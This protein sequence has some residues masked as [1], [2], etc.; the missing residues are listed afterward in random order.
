MRLA[1][2][3][4]NFGVGFNFGCKSRMDFL[5]QYDTTTLLGHV[6]SV[7]SQLFFRGTLSDLLELNW[8]QTV[9]RFSHSHSNYC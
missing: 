7:F 4:V 8:I 3:L 2:A 1:D 5:K 6:Q 9:T